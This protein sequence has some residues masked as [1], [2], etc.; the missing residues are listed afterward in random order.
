M[1]RF[2]ANLTLLFD[3][4]PYLDRFDAA[5][6]AG[7]E[8]V[9]ILSPY[10]FAAKDTSRALIANGLELVLINAPPPNYTGGERGFAAVP[11]GQQRF[12]HDIRRVSRYADVLKPEFIH[13]MAG[14]AEGSYAKTTFTPTIVGQRFNK[15]FLTKIG[16][17]RIGEI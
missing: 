17:Q 13:V 7:F 5:A 14:V 3:E 4:L 10:E 2:A 15:L 1:P 8:A 9:E 6:A 12:Q 11:G 16:P